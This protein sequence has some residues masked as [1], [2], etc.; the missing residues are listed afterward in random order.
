MSACPP[1][2][3]AAQPSSD[4]SYDTLRIRNDTKV[5]R[6]MRFPAG[7][8]QGSMAATRATFQAANSGSAGQVEANDLYI[9]ILQAASTKHQD[10]LFCRFSCSMRHGACGAICGPVTTLLGRIESGRWPEHR[11]GTGTPDMDTDMAQD[12]TEPNRTGQDEKRER[13]R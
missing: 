7:G 5:G 10:L 13:E 3:H 11:S 1:T 9:G 8:G 2:G 4:A 12:R 6:R